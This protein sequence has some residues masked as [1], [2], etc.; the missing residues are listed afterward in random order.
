MMNQMITEAELKKTSV[1]NDFGSSVLFV[2]TG[3]TCRSPMAE[4]VFNR[5]YSDG[6]TG[7]RA[8]SAGLFADG[9]GIS[10]NAENALKKIGITDFSHTSQNVTAEMMRR[11]EKVVGITSSHAARLMMAFP[12]FASKITSLPTDIPDP[13]GGDEEEYDK[14]L[15]TI[16]GA[17]REMFGEPNENN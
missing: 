11:S 10:A 14:C 13:Y 1:E 17:L 8:F 4:A 9:S 7:R 15:K 16:M 12:E 2:C 3:N 6:K 5:F